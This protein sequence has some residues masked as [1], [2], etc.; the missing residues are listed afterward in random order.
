MSSNIW[1]RCGGKS[2]LR[3]LAGAA[4]RVVES[5]HLVSTRKL[6]DSDAEQAVLEELIEG[7]KPPLPAARLHW[8]LA[9][10]FRYPPLRHGSR[11][12][13]RAERGIWYGSERQETAFAEKAY[14]ILLFLE[15]T[16]ASLRPLELD[17]S[18]FQARVS[19]DRGVDLLSACFEAYRTAISSPVSYAASQRLGAEM[20][21]DGVAVFRYASAR[22][23]G[24]GANVGIFDPEAFAARSPRPPQTWHCLATADV[25][26]L[27]KKD[28]FARVTLVFPRRQFERAGRLP[29]PAV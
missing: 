27:R 8:L 7:A 20:R 3:P 18:A 19:S 4:W 26:E 13:T 2:S 29:S 6:V 23:A 1:T 25:I 14:Y 11:F 28:V 15:G 5:Q 10:P 21:A 24:G 22:D 17:L 12:G 16:A 9:T